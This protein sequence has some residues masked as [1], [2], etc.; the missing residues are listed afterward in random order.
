MKRMKTTCVALV[1]I[2]MSL[3]SQVSVSWVSSM[4]D[5]TLK[6]LTLE[7]GG[8][9]KV[10]AGCMN[11]LINDNNDKKSF[12][13]MVTTTSR[14]FNN[15]RYADHNL[16]CQKTEMC[17]PTQRGSVYYFCEGDRWYELE[18]SSDNGICDSS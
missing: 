14:H 8:N 18:T 2:T 10:I 13:S 7:A 17:C 9:N 15:I 5:D 11:S 12:Y 16:S 4:T 6:L 1:A 3:V